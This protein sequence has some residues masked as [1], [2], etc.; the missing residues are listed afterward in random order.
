ML[1]LVL[2]VALV[3][4]IITLILTLGACG[5]GSKHPT[6]GPKHDSK[7]VHELVAE[8]RDDQKSGDYDAADK[9]YSEAFAIGKDFDVVEEQVDFLTHAGRASRAVEV[10]K[11][12]YDNNVSD[13]KGYALYA[14]ALLDAGKGSEA[15]EVADQMVQLNGDDPAG[16]EKK[17]RALVLIDKQDQGLDELRKA[18]RLDPK[19]GSYH[20]SLGNALVK[21]AQAIGDPGAKAQKLK[22]ATLAF[23]SAL[24]FSGDDSDANVYLG[25]ALRLQEA[26]DEAKGYLE[27]AIAIDA[28]NGRAYFELGLL[29]NAMKKQADAETALSKAV[30]LNPNESLFWYAYGELFRLQERYD[31]AIQAYKKAVDID[32]PWPKALT[33]LGVTYVERKQY[34]EAE[35]VLTQAIRREPKNPAN[36]LPLGVVYAAKG[37][38]KLAIDTYQKFLDLAPK[39]DEDRGRV[40]QAI[41][42]LKKSR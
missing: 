14:E 37:K 27:K 11:A 33:K 35:I 8:A 6:T 13:T 38:A 25:M 20:M 10:A 26:Y 9:A 32:P 22:E 42:E 7:Q 40:K 21:V 4:P 34:D 29:Y 30:Q 41:G 39:D 36:Y 17:G 12:Y 19:S 24:K 23:R 16:H 28:K 2:R 15:L 31:D 5:G 18:V 1:G 3:A